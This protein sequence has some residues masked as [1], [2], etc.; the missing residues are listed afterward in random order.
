MLATEAPAVSNSFPRGWDRG[1]QLQFSLSCPGSFQILRFIGDQSLHGWQ[2]VLL[3]NFIAARGLRDAAL[4]N[5]IFSQVVAQSWRNP[6]TERSRRGWLLMA[7]LLS[8]F[9][10]SPALQ[11]PLLK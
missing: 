9:G 7:T 4:R 3:G 8:C 1:L 10:P 5:E 6:D 11:K 2:E